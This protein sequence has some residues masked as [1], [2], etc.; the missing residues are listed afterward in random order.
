MSS[1]KVE[2]DYFENLFRYCISSLGFV[3]SHGLCT[4]SLSPFRSMGPIVQRICGE[5]QPRVSSEVRGGVRRQ[6]FSLN[7]EVN[8][9]AMKLFQ[10]DMYANLSFQRHFATGQ[11]LALSLRA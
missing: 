8:L 11:R 6:L 10:T 1:Y 5:T 3:V 4:K 7:I 9:H 2:G